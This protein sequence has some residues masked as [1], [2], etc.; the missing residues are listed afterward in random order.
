MHKKMSV[1]T[2][3]QKLNFTEQHI[4]KKLKDGSLSGEQVGKTWIVEEE[5]LNNF[6]LN[7]KSNM[8]PDKKIQSKNFL[9]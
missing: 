4:R 6:I 5:A 2:V 1:A 9:R 3:A 8:T 7:S